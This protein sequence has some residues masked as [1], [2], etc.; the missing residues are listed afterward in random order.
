MWDPYFVPRH[1]AH[2]IGH[3][4]GL[5]EDY[6]NPKTFDSIMGYQFHVYPRHYKNFI[7]WLNKKTGTNWSIVDSQKFQWGT[8]R[9]NMP[10]I[11]RSLE[12]PQ[13]LRKFLLNLKK[14]TVENYGDKIPMAK[15]DAIFS[16]LS[17]LFENNVSAVEIDYSSRF[18]ILRVYF[19]KQIKDEIVGIDHELI[20]HMNIVFNQ[21]IPIFIRSDLNSLPQ[22]LVLDWKKVVENQKLLPLFSEVKFINDV[23]HPHKVLGRINEIKNIEELK[24]YLEGLSNQIQLF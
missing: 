9:A 19:Y 12:N 22:F 21:N 11:I 4:L 18:Q 17:T 24:S 15:L 3:L 14:I 2:E 6:F 1:V 5:G 20:G 23:S 8:E 7:E 16:E 13:D 10:D